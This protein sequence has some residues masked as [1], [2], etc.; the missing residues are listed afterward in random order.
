[1]ITWT[2]TPHSSNVKRVGFDDETQDMQVEFASGGVYVV[3]GAGQAVYADMVSDPS[4]GGYY[5][6]HIRNRY[7][8][9]KL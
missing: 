6:K 7:P 4:P 2:D 8:V 1:M 5:N 3:P 9:R